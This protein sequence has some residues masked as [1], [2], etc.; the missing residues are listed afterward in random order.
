MGIL[1]Y[2]YEKRKNILMSTTNDKE[3]LL[4]QDS[5]ISIYEESENLMKQMENQDDYRFL[6]SFDLFIRASS[7]WE[8][9]SL[10]NEQQMRF[11]TQ[12]NQQF[13]FI[14]MI[15]AHF[16]K[17]RLS[18]QL[19]IKI[20]IVN[21][22]RNCI[23][24]AK[25]SLIQNIKILEEIVGQQLTEGD[26]ELYF[27]QIK[28]FGWKSEVFEECLL[29]LSSFD[30][31]RMYVTKNQSFFKVEEIIE[32][33]VADHIYFWFNQNKNPLLIYTDF[34]K[35]L[36]DNYGRLLEPGD[37]YYYKSTNTYVIQPGHFK[38][39]TLNNKYDF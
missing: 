10:D 9:F 28:I 20:K 15:I 35:K 11:K 30:G 39:N 26:I 12:R 22:R 31:E 8:A 17:F 5:D 23:S 13:K 2:I 14:N 36:L 19:D 21:K 29:G 32:Y 27:Q 25:K 7:V 33:Q 18:I 16:F 3:L 37:Y 24:Q 38:L 6:F 4:F 1:L 34:N